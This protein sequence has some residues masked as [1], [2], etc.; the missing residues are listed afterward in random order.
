M[1]EK[2]AIL[3]AFNFRHACKEL[4]P[5]S[6]FLPKSLSL[7]WKPPASHQAHSALSPG[8]LLSCKTK[9]YAKASSNTPGARRSNWI[10]PATLYFAWP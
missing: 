10:P 9:R 1:I 6:R 3:D 7:F 5:A 2:Q 8:T 4:T